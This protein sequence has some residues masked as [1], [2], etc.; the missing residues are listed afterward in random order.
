[1]GTQISLK[2]PDNLFDYA[3][4]YSESHGFSNLQEFI[5]ELIREKLFDG[6]NSK[7]G[8]IY[9]SIASEASLAKNWL[10][11]EED[12]AWFHLQEEK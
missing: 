8:G 10:T 1:M 11:K 6:E 3:K 9:T 4:E 5:R 12:E 7:V 2:L